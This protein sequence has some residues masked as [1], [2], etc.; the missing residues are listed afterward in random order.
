M[1]QRY[2]IVKRWV[3]VSNTYPPYDI[4]QVEEKYI[5]EKWL[6]EFFLVADSRGCSSSWSPVYKE[7]SSVES[8]ELFLTAYLEIEK[9]LEADPIVIKEFEI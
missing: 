3:N 2:R 1:K 8:A 4:T 9:L 5:I 7:F 6:G